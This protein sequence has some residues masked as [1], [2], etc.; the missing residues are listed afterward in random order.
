MAETDEERVNEW[1]SRGFFDWEREG[2]PYWSAL[3]HW[4]MFWRHRDEKNALFLHYA[5]IN[6]DLVREMRKIAAHLEI[7]INEK[8]FPDLVK[9]AGFGAMTTQADSLVLKAGTKL[10]NSNAQFFA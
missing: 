10:W 5:D 7:E 3:F 1:P 2:Y 9:A 8:A 4:E 6:Q